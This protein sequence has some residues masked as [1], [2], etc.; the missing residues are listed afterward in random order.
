MIKYIAI[1]FDATVRESS[2]YDPTRVADWVGRSMR[3]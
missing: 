3:V 1:E 2:S